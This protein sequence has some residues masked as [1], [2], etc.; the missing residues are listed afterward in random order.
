MLSYLSYVKGQVMRKF[1]CAIYFECILLFHIYIF[2]KNY[3]I[4]LIMHIS[5]MYC[6]G[7]VSYESKL[8]EFVDAL[9]LLVR[10]YHFHFF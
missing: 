3:C 5:T 4:S 7:K 1:V 10:V 6:F 2:A 9:C 8:S